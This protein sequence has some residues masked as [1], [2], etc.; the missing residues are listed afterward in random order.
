M[1]VHPISSVAALLALAGCATTPDY[2]AP[3]I[4]TS[5][6]QAI[7]PLPAGTAVDPAHWWTAWGDPVLDELV[8]RALAGNPD[9]AIAQSRIRQARLG[10][11]H[12]RARG[13]PSLAATGN[14]SRVDFSKNAG[15][16][17]IARAFSGGGGAG[18]T[19]GAGEGGGTTTPA[20]TRGVALPGNG[21]TTFALGFDADYELDLFGG[22]RRGVE[23]SRARTEVAGFTARDVAVSLAAEVAQA[24]FARRLDD[25]QVAVLTDEIAAQIR[26]LAI[27]RHRADVGLVPAIDVVSQSDPLTAT[28][29]RLQP[30]LADR[31]LRAHQLALLVGAEPGALDTLLATADAPLG[32]PSLVP[33][34]LPSDLLR[35]RP[36]VRRAERELAAATADIGVAVADLYPRFSLTGGVQLLSSALGSLF[37]LDSLQRTATAAGRFP[38]LDGGRG[39]AAVAGRREDRDQVYTRYQATVLGALKDVDDALVQLDAERTR[40]AALSDAVASG[41]RQVA[42]TTA[43]FRTGFVAED[44]VLDG[45]VALLSRREDLAASDARLR[46]YTVALFKAVGGGW[47]AGE[48][49]TGAV[50]GEP[51]PGSAPMPPRSAPTRSPPDRTPSAP[52]G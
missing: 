32:T 51:G 36:D 48:E 37:S 29:A 43:R 14:V 10:E 2:A 27:V 9:V 31:A 7:G 6:A 30:V 47:E 42:A 34:G 4:E 52:A 49:A 46:Q 20:P 23:A 38:L 44:V 17:S 12:A 13:L 21:I 33:A 19:P 35:R 40:N 45:R 3:A 28:R 8:A 18:E 24:Y 50:M 22:V 16:A 15:L 11:I 5:M 39:K 1:R 41:A 25:Q 26:Q